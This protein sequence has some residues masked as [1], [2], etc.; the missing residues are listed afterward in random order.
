MKKLIAIIV[1]FLL[2]FNL[3]A[4]GDDITVMNIVATSYKEQGRTWSEYEPTTLRLLW[5][6]N[7]GV[8]EINSRTYQRFTYKSLSVEEYPTY[9]RLTGMAKDGI[10]KN[11]SLTFYNLDTGERI[12]I[13]E[14]SDVAIRY[15]IH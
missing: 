10:N 2:S 12:F 1:L 4:Q 15:L 3:Y 13:V 11:V 5:N 7:T 8:I 9:K 6:V 14:Y